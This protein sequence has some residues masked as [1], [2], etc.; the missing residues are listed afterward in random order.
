MI[1]ILSNII[2]E[3]SRTR[4]VYIQNENFDSSEVEIKK[5]GFLHKIDLKFQNSVCNINIFTV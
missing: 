2:F 3:Q 4:N 5:P 1:K